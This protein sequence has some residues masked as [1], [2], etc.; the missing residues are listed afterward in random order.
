LGWNIFQP[1][2][3]SLSRFDLCYFR[4]TKSTEQKGDL[5]LFMKKCCQK[6]FLRSKKNIAEYTR[7]DQGLI[8]RIGSRKSPNHYRVYETRNGLRFE[9]EMKKQIL[10]DFLFIDHLK[11]FEDK[12][13]RH[14]YA[15]SKKMLLL[16]DSYTDWLM[17]YSRKT[18]KDKPINSLVTSYLI[19]NNLQTIENEKCVFRLLQFL[20]FSRR[21]STYEKD[22]FSQKYYV[23]Q[24]PVREFMD[25]IKI[26]NKNHYQ[27]KKVI[28]FLHD[29]QNNIPPVTIFSDNYFRSAASIPFVEIQKEH[30]SLVAKVLIAEQLYW[31]P[32]SFPSSFISYQT[33]HELKVKL[34]IIQCMST[35][36]LEKV[37]HATDF[38][39]QFNVSTQKQAHIKKL[40]VQSFHQ[41]QEDN[42]IQNQFKLITKSG[43]IKEINKISPLRVGQSKTILFYEKL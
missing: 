26:E 32:F 42:R 36:N 14:F 33:N 41:L 40:I 28:D 38:L 21:Y 4:E 18:D 3:L 37:F 30:K 23:I 7:N 17:D 34:R 29:L 13:T 43:R 8:L 15:H 20:S 5:E 10:Q 16:D 6:A 1:Y 9:L 24:F 22:L 27:L 39:K 25:F 35:N 11:N 2:S 12:L 19:S 31:Y